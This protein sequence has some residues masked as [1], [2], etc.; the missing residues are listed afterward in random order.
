MGTVNH[1]PSSQPHQYVLGVVGHA[2]DLMGNHL[3]DG[4]NQ[5]KASIHHTAVHLRTD[6]R[7]V[8]A[9]GH[10][11]AIG[12]RHR[13]HRDCVLPPVMVQKNLLRHVLPE[14]PD[15]FLTAHGPVGPHRRHD[16]HLCIPAQTVI[17]IGCD[18]TPVG[19][20]AC[21]IRRH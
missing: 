4:Q 20:T 6:I 21:D 3:A 17:Q 9:S 7:R 2:D 13:A 11:A 14:K 18:D 8:P 16:A 5:V 12:A 1:G 19:I 10:P 15:L